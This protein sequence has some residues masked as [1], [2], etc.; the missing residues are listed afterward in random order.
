[1]SDM[2]D[3]RSDLPCPACGEMSQ[4]LL[5]WAYSGLN[6]SIFNRSVCFSECR[7][8]G[9]VFNSSLTDGILADFYDTECSYF[10]K[11]HFD[12]SAPENQT[13]YRYYT[14]I[15]VNAGLKN[16]P[17]TDIGCG[18]GG[19]LIWLRNSGWAAFCQ[20]VD[21]DVKSIP[22]VDRKAGQGDAG[23]HFQEGRAVALPYADRS[24]SLLTYFHV[25]EHIVDFDKVLKEAS[26]VLSTG[27]HVMIEVPD[28]ARYRDYPIGTAFWLS[29]R[30]HVNH[31]SPQALSQALSRHGFAVVSIH[32]NILPTPE[33]SYPSLVVLANKA[34]T[35]GKPCPHHIR[36]IASFA[37]Q[38]KKELETQAQ[39]VLAFGVRYSP[40]T[41]WGCSA[42]LFSLL[43]LLN[44]TGYTICDSSKSK[45]Q[46]T[47]R[48]VP[49]E[50]PAVVRRDGALIIAPYL[51]G[52]EIERAAIALDWSPEAVL[53]LK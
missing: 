22:K 1:M 7:H 45:Q 51:F 20:G 11:P 8:C 49:V 16:R 29:I 17:I 38:S 42:E 28:A 14:D 27:G 37:V 53:R 32:R 39:E 5:Q 12:I 18:R 46:C 3:G 41:F 47:Y 19:Y 2:S 25:L 21:I 30:E 48:G 33:F 9:L 26:R 24:Q 52:D 6:D 34:E 35:T 40:F 43:P 23:M 4:H 13:K 15:L 50:D 44:L 36:N 31:F 10:E